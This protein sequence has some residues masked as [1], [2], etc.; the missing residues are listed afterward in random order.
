MHF[1]GVPGVANRQGIERSA[2]CQART[3]GSL[4]RWASEPPLRHTSQLTVDGDL[5]RL[6]AVRRIEY[7]AALP[8]KFSSR[9]SGLNTTGARSRTLGKTQPLRARIRSVPLL[10][11]RCNAR[12]MSAMHCPLVQ[13]PQSLAV[14]FGVN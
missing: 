11:L 12:A 3:S 7:P 14:C 2:Y 1:I 9:S 10:F 5:L 4:L 6:R 13:N 8:R